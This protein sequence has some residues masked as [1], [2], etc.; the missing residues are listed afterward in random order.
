MT[1]AELMDAVI[2][3][4]RTFGWT[5]AHFRPARTRRPRGDHD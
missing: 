2:D 3:A 5:V 4:A 1:E